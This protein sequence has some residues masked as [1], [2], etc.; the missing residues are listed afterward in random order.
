[1][2]ADIGDLLLALGIA[3]L[4]GIAG[5]WIYAGIMGPRGRPRRKD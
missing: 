1:V 4:I 2:V 5:G 3:A